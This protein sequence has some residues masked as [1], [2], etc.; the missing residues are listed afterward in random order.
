MAACAMEIKLLAAMV[1]K[2]SMFTILVE[3]VA[4]FSFST[5]K[6]HNAGCAHNDRS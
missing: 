5:P 6:G 1:D 2:K 4:V 3:D